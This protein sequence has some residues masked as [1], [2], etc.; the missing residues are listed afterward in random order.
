MKI[1]LIY[2]ALVLILA[3]DSN[4]FAATYVDIA[5]GLEHVDA[6]D[7]ARKY[8]RID[9]STDY[10]PGTEVTFTGAG[11]SDVKCYNHSSTI[12]DTTNRF[13]T[14]RAYDYSTVTVNNG[15]FGTIAIYDNATVRVNG[16]EDVSTMITIYDNAYCELNGF[17][18]AIENYDTGEVITNVSSGNLRDLC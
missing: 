4:S 13:Q 1:K 3:A 2:L 9:Y 12:F 5:D 18:T 14:I 16:T 6:T 17:F 8:P 15:D 7:Y 10:N 11:R